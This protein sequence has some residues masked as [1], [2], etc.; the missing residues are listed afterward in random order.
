MK[1]HV[2]FYED[3][4]VYGYTVTQEQNDKTY[5]AEVSKIIIDSFRKLKKEMSGQNRDE[6]WTS[7]KIPGRSTCLDIVKDYLNPDIISPTD[8]PKRIEK[9]E[10]KCDS[11]V[12]VFDYPD[13][14]LFSKINRSDF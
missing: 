7:Y 14:D 12:L 1:I 8:V 3:L 6:K 5:V 13:I 10:V 11:E 9:G 2:S 4:G